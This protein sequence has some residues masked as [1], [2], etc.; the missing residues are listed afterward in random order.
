MN[1]KY[2][3]IKKYLLQSN[4]Y[5][6][7]INLEQETKNKLKNQK[8]KKKKKKKKSESGLNGS[9][10]RSVAIYILFNFF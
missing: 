5:N 2:K 7:S 1:T 9:A 3:S 10:A 6:K 4:S 8:K